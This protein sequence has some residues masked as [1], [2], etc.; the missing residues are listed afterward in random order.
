MITTDFS[1]KGLREAQMRGHRDTLEYWAATLRESQDNGRFDSMWQREI[2]GEILQ[3]AQH[4]ARIYNQYREE[5]ERG[6]YE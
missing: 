5:R 6:E 1:L 4:L 3:E 2:V